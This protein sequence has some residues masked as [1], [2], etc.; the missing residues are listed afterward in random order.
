MRKGGSG[1]HC[2]T[3][4]RAPG[5]PPAAA[6]ASATWSG[7]I[8]QNGMQRATWRWQLPATALA[9]ASRAGSGPAVPAG[10]AGGRPCYAAG[11]KGGS[12]GGTTPHRTAACATPHRYL[13]VCRGAASLGSMHSATPLLL[14]DACMCCNGASVALAHC[15]FLN[16]LQGFAFD[17]PGDGT[18]VVAFDRTG[19]TGNGAVVGEPGCWGSGLAWQC[20]AVQCFPQLG[21]TLLIRCWRSWLASSHACLPPP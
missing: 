14:V 4:D 1:P 11:T 6:S 5:S 8:G 16:R 19:S 21:A 17:Y 2:R 9:A 12:S 18:W 7:A 3:T 10:S 20:G 15:I 13:N